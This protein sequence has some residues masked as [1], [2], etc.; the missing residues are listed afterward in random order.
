[1]ENVE[2][3]TTRD[4]YR[5]AIRSFDME[6]GCTTKEVTAK[7]Y[8]IFPE[9]AEEKQEKSKRK[10]QINAEINSAFVAIGITGFRC[11]KSVKPARI[12]YNS[13]DDECEDSIA[14]SPEAEEAAYDRSIVISNAV[15]TMPIEDNNRMDLFGYVRDMLNKTGLK[16][17]LD[18]STS[19]LEG[20]ESSHHPDNM[21]IL[22]AS[23]NRTKNS[24]SCD[25]FSFEEQ[26][27]YLLYKA[28]IGNRLGGSINVDMVE[29]L[30]VILKTIW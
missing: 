11:D 4:R 8:E 21:Q 3:K 23:A 24:K 12:Y 17:D 30:L 15:E 6:L 19:L 14:D 28:K 1:M 22:T 2:F 7:I 27:D 26:S 29:R 20:R 16:V 18:H 9:W 5:F 10:N 13:I 25:R